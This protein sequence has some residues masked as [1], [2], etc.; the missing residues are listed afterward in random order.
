MERD[1]KVLS[2]VRFQCATLRQ[3]RSGD[4]SAELGADPSESVANGRGHATNAG[5]SGQGNQHKQQSI[6]DQIL[7]LLVEEKIR[8]ASV[9]S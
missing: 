5:C 9:S 1:L 8:P 7:A 4:I 2:C 6:L 3:H